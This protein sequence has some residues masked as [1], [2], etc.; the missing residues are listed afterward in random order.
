MRLFGNVITA[1]FIDA[2]KNLMIRFVNIN[3]EV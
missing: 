2:E 1:S 3:D